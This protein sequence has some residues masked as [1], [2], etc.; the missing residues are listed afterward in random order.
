[1]TYPVSRVKTWINGET[2]THTDQN[3]EFDNV[4]T[5]VGKPANCDDYS[6]NAAQM[7]SQVDP[8]PGSAES[9]ATTLAGE[10]ERL[11]YQLAQITGNTYWYQDANA[12]L[13]AAGN[14][15]KANVTTTTATITDTI[16]ERTGAAGVTIDSVLLKD[17]AVTATTLTAN[18]SVV[19][20]TISEKTGAAGVTVD[21]VL[22]KDSQVTTDVINEKTAT[23]GV[24]IDGC[25]IKDGGAEAL[26]DGT[27]IVH[28]KVVSLGEWNMRDAGSGGADS[29][30][31]AHGLTAGNIIGVSGFVRDDTSANFFPIGSYN[32]T[33]GA[34]IN[35]WVWTW[36]ATNV[37]VQRRVGTSGGPWDTTSY[38]SG[39]LGT[40]GRGR[41]TIFYVE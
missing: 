39:A 36:D 11:R 17:N 15:T 28:C 9:L 5:N 29:V 22:L 3:A 33:D 21:G 8:Y 32:N 18:T 31:V 23:S 19:T 38:D 34:N 7:Q 40:Y 24:T 41:L 16:S 35:L 14:L 12:N 4:L 2:L 20:D 10:I 30:V 6:T 25:L 27:N 13:A 1:M 26:S 37:T